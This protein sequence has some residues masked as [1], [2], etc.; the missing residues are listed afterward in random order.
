[1][2]HTIV[3]LTCYHCVYGDQS[4]TCNVYVFLHLEEYM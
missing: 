2:Q 3:P 1:M 4:F